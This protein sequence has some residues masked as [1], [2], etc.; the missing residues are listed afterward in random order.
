[1]TP[2][3]NDKIKFM[4]EESPDRQ[5]LSVSRGG[6]RPRTSAD[7]THSNGVSYVAVSETVRR[8]IGK[9]KEA[10]L[11]SKPSRSSCESITKE[12]QSTGKSGLI[13]LKDRGEVRVRELVGEDSVEEVNSGSNYNLADGEHPVQTH[14]KSNV[15]STA[16]LKDTESRGSVEMEEKLESD[17]H[18]NTLDL[19]LDDFSA[20][21]PMRESE[22][23]S[24]LHN[25]TSGR[26]SLEGMSGVK[27]SNLAANIAVVTN[28]DPSLVL[29]LLISLLET[30]KEEKPAAKDLE[31][32]LSRDERKG[33]SSAYGNSVEDLRGTSRVSA[34]LEPSSS[35]SMALNSSASFVLATSQQVVSS[36]ATPIA[37]TRHITTSAG[38]PGSLTRNTIKKPISSVTPLVTSPY[39]TSKVRD[40]SIQCFSPESPTDTAVPNSSYERNLRHSSHSTNKVDAAVQ[41][42]PPSDGAQPFMVVRPEDSVSRESAFM[43]R[44]S[45]TQ[46]DDELVQQSGQSPGNEY[47]DNLQDIRNFRDPLSSTSISDGIA[48]GHPAHDIHLSPVQSEGDVEV[49]R[50]ESVE[51]QI[52]KILPRISDIRVRQS[53]GTF[54][55]VM[56]A[57]QTIMTDKRSI[58]TNS[59][60]S[61]GILEYMTPTDPGSGPSFNRFVTLSHPNVRPTPEEQFEQQLVPRAQSAFPVGQY[62][63][64]H[65]YMGSKGKRHPTAPPVT[66][67]VPP[68]VKF[69]DVQCVHIV[70]NKMLTLHNPCSRWVQ[71]EL[72]MMFYS[73]NG[74]QVSVEVQLIQFFTLS[75]L[76]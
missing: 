59:V 73:V 36:L 67:V 11:V 39:N 25:I 29:K 75:Q 3:E 5:D 22:A 55:P 62:G 48:D 57:N 6:A 32:G 7:I 1:M 56:A 35:G 9:E 60:R 69:Q 45:G 33:I 14:E 52:E 40:T 20:D 70:V 18:G 30:H 51:E 15:K 61:S 76:M 49:K 23:K 34:N 74:S 54:Y 65:G 31:R 28:T 8:S 63:L 42:E 64:S 71:C 13:D 50:P 41:Y 53:E 4:L 46:C 24:L 58:S 47:R 19:G 72:K 68:E 26:L 27:I 43:S 38:S 21:A 10:S 16:V 37:N 2:T 12:S 17:L 66:V 44:D